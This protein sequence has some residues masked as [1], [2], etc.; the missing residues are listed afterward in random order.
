MSVVAS[1]AGQ[2]KGVRRELYLQSHSDHSWVRLALK[3]IISQTD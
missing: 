1:T 2:E 3:E